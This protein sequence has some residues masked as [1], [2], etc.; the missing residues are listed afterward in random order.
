MTPYQTV[1]DAF[2]A[3]IKEDEWAQETDITVL[4]ED[5]RAILESAIPYFKFPRVSL[6]RDDLGFTDS[7]FTSS[8]VQVLATLMKIEWLERTILSWE[9]IKVQYEEKD[10]SQAN[11]L[12]KF[13]KLLELTQ[14]KA[15]KLEKIYY[16]SI[17]G[18]PYNFSKLAGG[19]NL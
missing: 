19:D 1:Y 16:R 8:E 6:E 13:T 18:K 5:W 2:L 4:L 15:T 11:L 14:K 3:K 10:F 12:D 9:N 7:A 17:N